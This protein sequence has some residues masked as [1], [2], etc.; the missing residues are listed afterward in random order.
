MSEEKK[1]SQQDMTLSY[2][3]GRQDGL[4]D[5]ATFLMQLQKD[6]PSMSANELVLSAFSFKAAME[7]AINS[8]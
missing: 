3:V 6:N 2:G 4:N 8:K 7:A 1:F 5:M